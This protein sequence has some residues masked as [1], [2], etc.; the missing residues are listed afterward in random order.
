M[1]M[2]ARAVSRYIRISPRKARIVAD[3]VR[4]KSVADALSILALTPKKAS[5]ILRKAILSA[6]AN[7]RHNSDE[8]VEA[9]DGALFV[10]DIR[11]DE[12]PMLKRIRPRAQGRAFR[13]KKR[14]SHIRVTV[15]DD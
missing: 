1:E 8:A 2:E 14:T 11:I 10:K 6:A 4:G 13:I 7:V 5:P 12:G 15:G 9:A 3:L